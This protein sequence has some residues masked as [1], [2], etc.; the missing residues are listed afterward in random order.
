ME[1]TNYMLIGFFVIILY[2]FYQQN[3]Q[4]NLT[5]DDVKKKYISESIKEYLKADTD[6]KD[7]LVFLTKID[8]RSYKLI[9]QETFYEMKFLLKNNLL[10]VDNIM[11]YMSDV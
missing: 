3:T 7:F 1:N 8:N 11:K 6:Y 4:E 5:V 10:T 9:Q 2:I